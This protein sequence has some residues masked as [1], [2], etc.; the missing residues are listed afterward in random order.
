MKQKMIAL[1]LALAVAWAIFSGP[2]RYLGPDDALSL[3]P[4][5]VLCISQ[6]FARHDALVRGRAAFALDRMRRGGATVL[7]VSH[8]EEL[9]R[10]LADEIWWLREGTIGGRGDPGG[11]LDPACLGPLVADEGDER[12]GDPGE[13]DAADGHRRRHQPAS[14]RVASRPSR[15]DTTQASRALIDW[16]VN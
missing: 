8:E 12:Q 5:A 2:T 14:R 11:E 3:A 6:T 15:I 13:D 4:A 16:P 7:L 9:L 10:R 1:A